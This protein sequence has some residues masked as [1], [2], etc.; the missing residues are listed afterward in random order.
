M[1]LSAL[2]K[3]RN[4]LDY[5]L[6]RYYR[7]GYDRDGALAR[8]RQQFSSAGFDYDQSVKALDAA[9]ARIGKPAF[10]NDLESVHWLV[11]AA[12]S[13]TPGIRRILEI[14]TFDGKFTSVLA[15][16]FPHAEITTLDLPEDDPL[17][18][19]SY[20]RGSDS[21][22]QA[23]LAERAANL[24]A[25]NIRALKRNSF[26]LLDTVAGPFDVIWVDGGH[27]YPEVAWDLCSAHHLVRAG[28]AVLCDDV[29][30]HP[31][32]LHDEYV[33]PQSH[34]VLEYAAQRGGFEVS[35]FLKRLSGKWSA[36][37]TWR[38]FVAYYRKPS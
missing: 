28:G 37:P 24:A 25:P 15:A 10:D 38:K 17:L 29:I 2:L 23:H 33:S 36:R 7:S 12:L 35:Y 20:D 4:Y 30:M 6:S 3:P 31:D 14:G 9:L 21:E 19:G 32:G 22:L 8:L 11:F 16:L 26:F 13:A 1:K 5:I 34:A 18:R 27:L